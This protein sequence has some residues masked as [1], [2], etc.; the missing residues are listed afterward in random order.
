MSIIIINGTIVSD[1]E[2]YQADIKITGET[3]SCIGKNLY[4]DDPSDTII[5]A[6][7]KFVLPGGIDV[8][9]HLKF[10]DSPFTGTRAAACGGTTTV[11]DF[12]VYLSG[13]DIHERIAKHKQYCSPN[14]CVDYAIHMAITDPKNMKDTIEACIA[15]GITSFKAYMVYDGWNLNDADIL[16][17]LKYSAQYGSLVEIHAENK[18]LLDAFTQKYLREAPQSVYAHYLAR[19]EIVEVTAIEQVIRLAHE[20]KAPVYIAHLSTAEGV[21]LISKA[22]DVGLPVFTETCPHYLHFT[23]DVYNRIDGRNFVCSPSIK[24]KESKEA[25]LNGLKYNDIDIVASD[26]CTYTQLEKDTFTNFTE[27]PNGC[28][29]VETRYPYVLSLANKGVISFK[30]AV[31]LCAT[32]PAKMFGCGNR[33]G[34]LTPGKDADIVIYDPQRDFVISNSNMHGNND[35]TIWEGVALKGYPEAVYCRGKLVAK[36]NMFV[37]ERGAG[38]YIACNQINLK[39]LQF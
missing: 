28:P 20:A 12:A 13:D 37:G 23:S 35:Q 27:I 4:T 32:I 24:Q 30:K 1:R 14:V 3:I 21:N 29:G 36:D 7:G 11:F 19:P 8:H 26:H 15:E 33:K 16:K 39:T 2:M 25:L 10:A 17:M 38:K 18:S 34:S 9:T 22:K 31:E 5:D 6:A